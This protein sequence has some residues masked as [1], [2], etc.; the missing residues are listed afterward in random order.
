MISTAANVNR[1]KFREVY[2]GGP[3]QSRTTEGIVPEG[4]HHMWLFIKIGS[5]H[6]VHVLRL[7]QRNHVPPRRALISTSSTVEIRT[8]PLGT[9]HVDAMHDDLA[10]GN[11]RG[12]RQ[13]ILEPTLHECKRAE[14]QSSELYLD[15]EPLAM[16]S[17]RQTEDDHQQHRIFFQQPQTLGQIPCRSVIIILAASSTSLRC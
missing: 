6:P 9:R 4:H 7:M 11:A 8:A 16:C 5:F 13:C 14:P 3:V 12:C 10:F 15:P 2:S 1:K 17:P